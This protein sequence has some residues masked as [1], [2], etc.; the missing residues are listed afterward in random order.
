[1]KYFKLIT[2]TIIS[3]IILVTSVIAGDIYFVP[4]EQKD[5]WIEISERD[6]DI[7]SW[8]IDTGI[9][10]VEDSG[11]VIVNAKASATIDGRR[12]YGL[13][14]S[15]AWTTDSEYSIY[16]QWGTDATS[17]VYISPIKAIASPDYL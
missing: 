13:V 4:G 3:G 14:D 12:V 2:I 16:I 10:W 17:E 5:V 15:T 7:T 8:T 11:N 1:M 6:G 9:F